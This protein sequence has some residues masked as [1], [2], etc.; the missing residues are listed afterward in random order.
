MRERVPTAGRI[1]SSSSS[2]A[3]FGRRFGFR[4]DL[5]FGKGRKVDSLTS[6]C[7]PEFI[8]AIIVIAFNSSFQATAGQA[9]C[10][11]LFPSGKTLVPLRFFGDF[12]RSWRTGN[13]VV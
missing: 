2:F 1:G 4:G 5:R 3:A 6:R 8:G 11:A 7:P 13:W 10:R 12:I 9:C